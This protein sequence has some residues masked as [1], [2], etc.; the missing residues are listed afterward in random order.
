MRLDTTL[1]TDEPG[2]RLVV[3]GFVT[4]QP[5]LREPAGDVG[6]AQQLVPDPISIRAGDGAGEELVTVVSGCPTARG[7]EDQPAALREQG[8]AGFGLELAPDRVR[9]LDQRRIGLAL[10][11]RLAG[12]ARVPVRGAV[13]VRW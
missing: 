4:V 13:D 1:W 2:G 3:R 11:D 5:E 9:A 10:A 8:Q 6:G 12:D 7:L